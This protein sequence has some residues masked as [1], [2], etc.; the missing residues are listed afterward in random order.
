MLSWF[1]EIN[2]E[3]NTACPTYGHMPIPETVTVVSR[4]VYT[5]ARLEPQAQYRGLG[6]GRAYTAGC[7]IQQPPQNHLRKV[8][9]EELSKGGRDRGEQCC[10]EEE[11]MVGRIRKQWLLPVLR[12][13]LKVLF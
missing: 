9:E 12:M 5:L 10:Y 8:E 6:R 2:P 11:G 4:M 1:P 13:Y 7:S 3:N